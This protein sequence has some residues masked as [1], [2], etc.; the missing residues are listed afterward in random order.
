LEIV[1]FER[2]FNQTIL[3]TTNMPTGKHK[4][5]RAQAKKYADDF[6]KR[7]KDHPDEL[8]DVPDGFL[9]DASDVKTLMS[10]SGTEYFVIRFG[11]KKTKRKDGTEKEMIAPILMVLNKDFEIIN[12]DS[13]PLADDAI[14]MRT[15]ET[16]A[17][18]GDDGGGFLDEGD[19]IPPPPPPKFD[20]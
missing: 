16:T 14:A 3:K 17:G 20:I 7:K 10:A 8:K 1:F 12:P 6:D 4:I 9:F 15:I 5:S 11:W 13:D 2:I 18:D 19:P